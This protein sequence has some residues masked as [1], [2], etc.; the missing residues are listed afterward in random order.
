MLYGLNSESDLEYSNGSKVV[1]SLGPNDIFGSCEKGYI[2]TLDCYSLTRNNTT[3]LSLL[4]LNLIWPEPNIIILETNI[5][6]HEGMFYFNLASVFSPCIHSPNA[7]HGVHSLCTE[8]M[9]CHHGHHLVPIDGLSSLV[10]YVQSSRSVLSWYVLIG[11][12]K[13]EVLDSWSFT[14]I[15]WTVTQQASAWGAALALA[16]IGAGFHGVQ[17]FRCSGWNCHNRFCGASRGYHACDCCLVQKMC[18]S[19]TC[20]VGDRCSN[21]LPLWAWTRYGFSSYKNL[22]IVMEIHN[23]DVSTF[24]DMSWP[25]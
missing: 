2:L 18:I 4:C 13:S 21:T 23:F 15:A 12:V 9:M 3:S 24:T 11:M 6:D 20:T 22:L 7:N 25:A 19:F 16:G 14:G 1:F 17:V 5:Q 10:I 8:T